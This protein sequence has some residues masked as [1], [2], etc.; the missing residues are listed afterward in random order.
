MPRRSIVAIVWALAAAG[1]ATAATPAAAA[2]ATGDVTLVRHERPA[3]S[4]YIEGAIQ[5]V[6]IFRASTGRRVL[7][8]RFGENKRHRIELPVG[9]YRIRSATRVCDGNCGFL[10]PPSFGCKGRFTAQRINDVRVRIS[11]KV[12]AKCRIRV[13]STQVGAP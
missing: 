13:T 5:E 11:T 1:T 3:P 7:T 8:Y 9:R 4:P 2:A 10:D 6:R 12:G